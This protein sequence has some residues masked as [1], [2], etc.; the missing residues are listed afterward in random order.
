MKISFEGT[1]AE[2][3]AFAEVISSGEQK[4]QAVAALASD[5]QK[6]A[7]NERIKELWQTNKI[8]A[9]KLHRDK[10]N[11]SLKEAKDYCE[12]LCGEGFSA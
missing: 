10:T 6:Q 4:T 1:Y 2:L 7:L 12:A 8:A 11:S 9:I 5:V 3:L